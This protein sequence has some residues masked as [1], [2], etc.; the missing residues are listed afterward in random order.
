MLAV[1]L[2]CCVGVW[3]EVVKAVNLTDTLEGFE[4]KPLKAVDVVSSVRARSRNFT[5][6]YL[7]KMLFKYKL[8]KTL[9]TSCR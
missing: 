4:L 8:L 7:K 3:V 2:R 5:V 9:E 1:C 6:K